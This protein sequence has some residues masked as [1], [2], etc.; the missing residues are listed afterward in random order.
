MR[1]FWP[2]LLFVIMAATAWL[3]Q[4][5]GTAERASTAE[6]P[7]RII[8]LAPSITETL[9]ALG[10]DN[11]ITAVTDYCVYPKAAQDKP[12]IGGYLD[13]SLETLV[14]LRPDLVIL[15]RQHHRLAEQLNALGIATREVDNSRLP[16][17][18]DSI[19]IIGESTGAETAARQLLDDI[20][21]RIKAIEARVADLP[22]PEVLL[23]I[24]NYNSGEQLNQVYVAGQQDFYNDLL[25]IAGG[26]NVYQYQHIAVP[27]VSREG[28]MRLNPEVIIDI[29]PGPDEHHQDL[30]KVRQRWQQ[31]DSVQAIKNKRLHIIEADYA[32]KPGPR[33]IDLLEDLAVMIH[34]QLH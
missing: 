11:R 30:S 18:L 5:T 26:R 31:L 6:S 4:P 34:P 12:S 23:S 15:L 24:A 25:E 29:F 3:F 27:A 13:P 1:R 8:S 14:A 17:I 33:V 9:F 20:Q 7:E 28:L 22:R 21:S 10:L 19:R 32:T 2:L 16:D